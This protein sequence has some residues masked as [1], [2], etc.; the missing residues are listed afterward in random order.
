MKEGNIVNRD[1]IPL[2]PTFKGVRLVSLGLYPWVLGSFK[3]TLGDYIGSYKG[4][5]RAILV[6]PLGGRP[7]AYNER[8][9]DN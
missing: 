9:L 2:F 6:E 8:T 3:E 1:Q 7:L 5:I 4:Y